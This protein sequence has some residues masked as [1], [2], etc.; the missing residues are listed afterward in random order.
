M[1]FGVTG[2]LAAERLTK[3]RSNQQINTKL[4]TNGRHELLN[5]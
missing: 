3:K 1:F 2:A 4:T 5:R